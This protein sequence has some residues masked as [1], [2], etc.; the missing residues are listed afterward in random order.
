M[1]KVR[2][3]PTTTTTT[4]SFLRTLPQYLLAFKKKKITKNCKKF[5]VCRNVKRNNFICVISDFEKYLSMIYFLLQIITFSS[6][7]LK[8]LSICLNKVFKFQQNH[9]IIAKDYKTVLKI[10]NSWHVENR[11][12]HTRVIFDSHAL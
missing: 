12:N 8:S 4:K 7:I 10:I 5:E 2:Q 6:F 9:L 1:I 11:Q 3:Y